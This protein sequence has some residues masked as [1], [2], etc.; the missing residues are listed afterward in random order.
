MAVEVDWIL[1]RSDTGHSFETL[2]DVDAE[3]IFT[4]A[5]TMYSAGAL[6]AGTRVLTILQLLGSS[7]KLR[8]YV[9]NNSSESASQVFKHLQALLGIWERKVADAAAVEDAANRPSAARFGR[10]TRKPARVKEYPGY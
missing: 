8:D 10:T 7:A 2:N 3:A 1:L 4:Q 6:Y 9:Q 5:A